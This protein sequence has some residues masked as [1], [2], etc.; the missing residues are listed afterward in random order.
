M[1]Q[2]RGTRW[3]L[4]T[5]QPSRPL[6]VLP[7]CAL[8]EEDDVWFK[9]W[10][11]ATLSSQAQPHAHGAKSLLPPNHPIP[12][13]FQGRT[14]CPGC[15]SLLFQESARSQQD[16]STQRAGACREEPWNSQGP[17]R[18]ELALLEAAS[19]GFKPQEL[20][21]SGTGATLTPH[22]HPSCPKWCHSL[23]SCTCS[24]QP[25]QQQRQ[26]NCRTSRAQGRC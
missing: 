9:I 2:S 25:G 21:A 13:F 24:L 26:Q 12:D 14:H 4:D 23:C 19:P 7:L 1:S 5:L 8:G 18:V 22:P 20:V 10:P 15:S 3:R 16:P 17:S 11:F 6:H